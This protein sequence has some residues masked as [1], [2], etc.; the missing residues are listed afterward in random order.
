MPYKF[1]S[2]GNIFKQNKYLLGGTDTM[3]NIT[4]QIVINFCK[5]VLEVLLK[6]CY[7]K[8]WKCRVI[9][10][11]ELDLVTHSV[12][13]MCIWCIIW[14]HA[15]KCLGVEKVLELFISSY[16]NVSGVASMG[17]FYMS[18]FYTSVLLYFYKN[19]Y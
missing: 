4:S 5:M 19:V 13:S 8:S 18:S 16:S 11:P 3:Y 14:C 9:G 12:M 10:K 2:N 17:N 7:M 1:R 6:Y 15:V